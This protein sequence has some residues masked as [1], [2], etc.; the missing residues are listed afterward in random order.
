MYS[1]IIV[2]DEKTIR[3]NLPHAVD[4][5][6]YGFKV[7]ATARNGEEALEVVK[8]HK[9]DVILL[10]VCMPILDGLGFLQK[11]HETKWENIPYIVMLSGYS[12]FEYARRALRYGVKAYLSK[13]LDEDELYEILKEIREELNT[14]SQKKDN[15]LI[16]QAVKTLLKMYYDGDGER[17]IFKD[18]LLMHCVILDTESSEVAYSTI[19]DCI[20]TKVTDELVALFKHRGSIITY[21]VSSRVLEEYQFSTTLFG[22]HILYHIK[23]NNIE[24]A[25]LF[26]EKLFKKKNTTFR[27]DYDMHLYQMMTEVF[28]GKERIIPYEENSL[29]S[30]EERRL[31]KEETYLQLLKT[32]IKESDELNLKELYANIMEE[33]EKERLNIIFIQEVNYRIYYGLMDVMREIGEDYCE[34]AL[35][36]FEWRDA[37][38][39]VCYS[40]WK[41]LIW[42]QIQG[43]F[44]YVNNINNFNKTGIGEKVIA[45]IK[46]HY[47]E[48]ISLK[49]VA[50]IFYVNPVYLGKCVQKILGVTFKQYVN[51]LRIQEA[52]KLL[53]DTDK[54]IY[55]IAEEVGFSESKYFISKFTSEVGKSPLE[56]KK[57][58]NMQRGQNMH[59]I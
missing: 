58:Q 49:G 8:C 17:E 25:L 43:V 39:F 44:S 52:K 15:E 21:L 28:W 22:R 34:P 33:V 23:K 9:P 18:Y 48:P 10:D 27:N 37:T 36:P 30:N 31:E 11:L 32:R 13:P 4:F 14:K 38:C 57:E 26:D 55:E 2:D 16:K 46:H 59:K 40:K 20:E 42:E 51:D 45:Y 1:V 24:C 50:E 19:Q 53:R 3:E 35:T 5:E 56:Y 12:D 29:N 7:C 54:L 6:Q 47:K 41:E